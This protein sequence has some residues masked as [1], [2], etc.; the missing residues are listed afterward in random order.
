M[1]NN[2]VDLEDLVNKLYEMNI[3]S[4]LVEG[5]SILNYDF[6][7]EGLVDKIYEFISPQ[8][9]GG[10]NSKSPFYGRGVDKIKDGY[11]FEIEDV[12]RF[13]D[14]IMIEAKNVHWNI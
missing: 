14:D 11:K 1:K 3:G 4:I 10:F 6:L 5:G 12:K 9:I 8:I 2:H 13:D 7:E